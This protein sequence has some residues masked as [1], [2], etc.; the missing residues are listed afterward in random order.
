MG[1]R[2]STST[3]TPTPRVPDSVPPLPVKG[4]VRRSSGVMRLNTI[5]FDLVNAARRIVENSLGVV[6]G[7]RMLIIVDRARHDIAPALV[8]VTRNLGAACELL[9]LEDIEARPVREVPAVI[10][11]AMKNAQASILLVGFV[12]GEQPMRGDY[13]EAV[14]VLG[15]R[16]A[17]MVGVTKHSMLAGFSVD[18]ARILD[19]TRAVRTR[20]R[21]DS[22]L[23]VRSL[24]GTNLTVK[25]N[26]SFR[27]AE[28]VGVIRPGRWENLPSGELMTSPGEI[29]GLFV[30]DASMGG[31]FGQAAGLLTR[32]PVRFEIE[33]NLVKSVS[34]SNHALQ[35]DVESFLRSEHHADRV[36]TIVLGTNV[37]ILKP[38][39][40]LICDQNL[41]GLHLGLGSTFPDKTGA[42]S[43]TRAQLSLTAAGSDVDLDGAPLLRSGRYMIV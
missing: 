11:A 20:L 41:P 16:H 19:T 26:P 42:P 2:A 34:S 24:A 29:S 39:G 38:V 14:R 1:P 35:R 22:V 21:S 3:F 23:K 10:S 7:E 18:P 37:G 5:D 36:G 32:S 40:E 28:H 25:L 27:W 13:L 43:T 4:G 31:P 12:D 6:R 8:E 30:C 17:H 9:I 33:A 15:L